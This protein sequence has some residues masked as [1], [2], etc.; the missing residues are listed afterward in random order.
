[1]KELGD[2]NYL[3]GICALM[4]DNEF[5]FNREREFGNAKY[6]IICK[7]EKGQKDEATMESKIWDLKQ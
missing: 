3:K 7:L 1:V 2:K 6:V 4:E 5:I